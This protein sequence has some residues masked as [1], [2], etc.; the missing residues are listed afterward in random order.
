LEQALAVSERNV[1]LSGLNVMVYKNALSSLLALRNK[2]LVPDSQI[3]SVQTMDSFL[4]Q[5]PVVQF[6]DPILP[7]L[8]WAQYP[9][10]NVCPVDED[11]VTA[12]MAGFFNALFQGAGGTLKLSMTGGYEYS[13]VSSMA[14]LPRTYLPLNMLSPILINIDP[15]TP[16]AAAMALTQQLESWYNTNQPTTGGDAAITF[17]FTLFSNINSEQILFSI[18][19]LYWSVTTEIE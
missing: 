18:D 2:F 9:L 5:T 19:D 4:F 8:S 12:Y 7:R 16:P 14:S 10:R 13:L 11:N 1:A 15:D 17:K 6:T 3:G